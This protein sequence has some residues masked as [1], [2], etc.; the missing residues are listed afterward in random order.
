MAGLVEAIGVVSGL[1]S[2]VNFGIDNFA[3]AG[4][5]SRVGS[6]IKVAVALEGPNGPT[7]AGG[8]LPDV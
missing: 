4:D 7:N 8:D 5:G 1:L 3:P 2:V 6:V